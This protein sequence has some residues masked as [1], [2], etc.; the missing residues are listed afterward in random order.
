MGE[1]YE[2]YCPPF[3]KSNRMSCNRI[4]C[5]SCNRRKADWENN[6]FAKN[7]KAKSVL[8]LSFDDPAE[9]LSAKNDAKTFIEF[10]QPPFMFDEIPPKLYFMDTGL[11]AYLTKWTNPEVMQNGAMSGAF[12]E[13]YAVAEVIKSFANKGLEPPIYF[14]RDKDK[15]EIDLLIEQ[16]GTVFHIE[17][18]KKQVQIQTMQKIF[19]SHQG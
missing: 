13:T 3:R 2:I 6:H 19:L 4:S 7:H 17:I 5:R 15:I 9:E 14:Y 10:H 12:F 18:K 16:N 1:N 8:Y 11:A